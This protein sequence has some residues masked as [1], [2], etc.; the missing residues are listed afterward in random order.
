MKCT[1]TKSSYRWAHEQSGVIETQKKEKIK[2]RLKNLTDT[3]VETAGHSQED[4][5]PG[6][7]PAPQNADTEPLTPANNRRQG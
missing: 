4:P 5:P 3:K 1:G 7:H 2:D 6:G